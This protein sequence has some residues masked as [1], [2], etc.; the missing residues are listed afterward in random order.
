MNCFI[1]SRSLVMLTF[2]I[3]TRLVRLKMN[4]LRIEQTHFLTCLRLAGTSHLT[5]LEIK[6][7]LYW[8]TKHIQIFLTIRYDLMYHFC[9]WRAGKLRC[10]EANFSIRRKSK[11]KSRSWKLQ[12]S[13]RCSRKVMSPKHQYAEF[14]FLKKKTSKILCSH[15]VNVLGAWNTFTKIVLSNGSNKTKWAGYMH[16]L[17]FTTGRVWSVSC[18]RQLIHAK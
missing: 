16:V 12:L 6:E 3:R 1:L 11:Q 8:R 15:P 2:L 4:S 10:R 7:T 18:A 14:A 5:E 13:K 9:S 17:A